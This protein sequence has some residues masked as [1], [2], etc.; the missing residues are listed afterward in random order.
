[1]SGET[2]EVIYETN[3]PVE[4]ELLRGLLEAN[5]IPA[6]LSQEGAGKAYGLTI[7][8]LG[9][10]QILV[11]ESR[12]GQALQLIGDL[13]SGILQDQRFEGEE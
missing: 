13:Q 5:Q 9:R 1:M 2:W 8:R 11:P 10:V 3:E 7:G 6:Y 4:A 12:Y